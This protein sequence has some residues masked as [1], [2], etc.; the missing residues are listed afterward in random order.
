MPLYWLLCSASRGAQAGVTGA[1]GAGGPRR[2]SLK[3]G[4]LRLQHQQWLGLASG[5]ISKRLEGWKRRESRESP[6]R[7]LH[8]K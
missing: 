1:D 2:S 8:L 7:S 4:F 6:Q 5:A 3:A